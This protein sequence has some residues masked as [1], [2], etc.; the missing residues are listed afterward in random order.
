MSLE[1]HWYSTI[2]GILVMGGQ[3]MNAMA[4]VI[5]ITALLAR[6]DG[7]LSTV[8]S[9][10]QFHDLGKL[11]LAFVML[12]AYFAF[13]Q[14]LIMWS[15]N[16]PEEIPWYLNRLHGG[17][18]IVGIAI[19]VFHFLLPFFLLLSRDLK[20]DARRL[21]VVA[22]GIMIIRFVDLFWLVTPAF[23]PEGLS[24]HWL[25][26]ATLV[27]VGGIWLSVFVWQLNGHPLVAVNDP[28]LPTRG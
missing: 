12:W 4:F 14:L 5:A 2:Y 1:P 27:G 16:L 18:Q 22:V 28:S 10:G 26:A 21:A 25:D 20:R 19:I 3:V 9:A 23:H 17:W 8:I 24:V 15:G 13:S 11:L 7:P 6:R